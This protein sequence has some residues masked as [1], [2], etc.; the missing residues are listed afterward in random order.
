M[1]A[2]S[3]DVGEGVPMVPRNVCWH[4]GKCVGQLSC[5]PPPPPDYCGNPPSAPEP[6]VGG[7]MGE[8]YFSR[9]GRAEPGI[10]TLNLM[11]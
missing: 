10:T 9:V 4:S 5:M 7:G 6:Q 2:S 8:T 1:K 3:L 11:T